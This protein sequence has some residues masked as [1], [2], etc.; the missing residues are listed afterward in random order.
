[1][2]IKIVL[3]LSIVC[4]KFVSRKDNI[5]LLGDIVLCLEDAYIP[6]D[7]YENTLIEFEVLRIS[8]Y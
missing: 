3:H 2:R 7:I 8:M 1:M 5:V 4:C 6:A